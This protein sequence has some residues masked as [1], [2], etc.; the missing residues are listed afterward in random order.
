MTELSKLPDRLAMVKTPTK[1]FIRGDKNYY[2]N[3]GIAL[4]KDNETKKDLLECVDYL[5][6][7]GVL[8]VVK[9]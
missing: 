9:T 4:F 3:T 8:K 6:Q 5:V 7:V 2:S 1:V